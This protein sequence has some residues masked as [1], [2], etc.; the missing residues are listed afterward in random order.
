MSETNITSPTRGIYNDRAASLTRDYE[1]KNGEVAPT[2]PPKSSI[3]TREGNITT[4]KDHTGTA[5]YVTS[6]T[7]LDTTTVGTVPSI[8]EK[9]LAAR[10]AP[11]EVAQLIATQTEQLSV[12]VY[13]RLPDG[14]FWRV[15]SGG[16]WDPQASEVLLLPRKDGG[17]GP[18]FLLV[19]PELE[20]LFQSDAKLRNLVRYHHLAFA[21]D[22]RGRVGWWAIP[23][24]SENDWHVSARTAMRRLMAEWGMMKSDQG[25]KSYVLEKPTDNLGEPI[26]PVGSYE[27]WFVKGLAD[28]LIDSPDHPVVR[29]LQ[30]RK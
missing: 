28:K 17:G 9:I 12:S 6:Q 18:E 19:L 30:G 27:D 22:S 14:A 3:N 20:P 26:W 29:E 7:A 5:A 13:K 16:E 11:E 15:R 10:K 4:R 21:V 2:I 23:S 1:K 24:R 25:A 8:R